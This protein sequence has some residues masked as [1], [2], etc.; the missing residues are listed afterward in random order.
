MDI[1]EKRRPGNGAFLELVNVTEHNLKNISIK[2][3]LGAFTCITGVSGSGKSTLLTDVL[4]PAVS[5]RLMRSSIQ[6]G[7]YG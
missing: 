6:E 2:I 1:P 5:N 7:A 4:Y 3:P